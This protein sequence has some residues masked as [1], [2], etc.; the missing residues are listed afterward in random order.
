VAAQGL[1]IKDATI[2][3]VSEKSNPIFYFT[4]NNFGNSEPIFIISS[5]L[6]SERIFGG[7]WNKAITSPGHIFLHLQK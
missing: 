2:H 6:N 5:L 3:R 7:S 1:D 4:I